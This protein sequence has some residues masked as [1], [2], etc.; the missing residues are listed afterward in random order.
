MGEVGLL[1][2]LSFAGLLGVEVGFDEDGFEVVAFGLLLFNFLFVSL[3]LLET[4]VVFDHGF[5]FSQ[6]LLFELVFLFHL[7]ILALFLL[8]L[9]DFVVFGSELFLLDLSLVLVDFG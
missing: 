7:E 5:V 9:L 4:I 6:L 8:I 1:L 3:F 2:F